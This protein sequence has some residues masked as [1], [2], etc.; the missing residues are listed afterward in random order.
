MDFLLSVSFIIS[1]Q[2]RIFPLNIRDIIIY[3]SWWWEKY[4]SKRSL[5]KH[6]CSWGDKLMVLFVKDFAKAF[7]KDFADF[8]LYR[9]VKDLIIY[10]PEGF[11]CFSH[12]QFTTLLPF[13]SKFLSRNTFL[14][15]FQLI[16]LV[17]SSSN[18]H[19]P[20]WKALCT[21]FHVVFSCSILT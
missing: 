3:V 21:D 15:F 14:W 18:S 13:L 10:F 5:I 1:V 2:V 6:T 4:L 17:S 7:S 20:I 19:H 8:P 9:T 16:F 11:W 12:Y